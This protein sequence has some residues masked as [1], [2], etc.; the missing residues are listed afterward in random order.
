MSSR[1]GF[2]EKNNTT[3]LDV[4]LYEGSDP[5]IGVD[6]YTAMTDNGDGSY[7]CDISVSKK[8]TLVV[9]G[10]IQDEVR[11]RTLPSSDLI[12]Q[13]EFD[14]HKNADGSGGTSS[15]PTNKEHNAAAIYLADAGGR[16]S[17]TDIEA[18]LQEIAGSGRTT[19]TVKDNYDTIQNHLHAI[20]NDLITGGTTDALSAEMGKDLGDDIGD[21][22]FSTSTYLANMTNL[23]N[24]LLALDAKI[25][26]FFIRGSEPGS[27]ANLRR[28]LLFFSYDGQLI[29]TSG[30]LTMAKGI[31]CSATHGIV[32]TR[33]GSITGI[34]ASWI[35]A[36]IT[37]DRI[38][39]LKVQKNGTDLIN[40]QITDAEAANLKDSTTHAAGDY[41]FSAGD[42]IGMAYAI[43]A[44]GDYLDDVMIMVELTLATS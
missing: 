18:A 10:V 41:T 25:W 20:I 9:E 33:A 5:N 17:G 38:I 32:M 7:Y 31:A 3:G 24:A 23:T 15:P 13:I 44:S 22:D 19:Q 29:G 35:G 16:Y 39:Y 2:R 30:Y 14:A 42:K 1:I 26:E 43:D 37:S 8:Y 27:E 40:L 36:N 34:S 21:M 11:G 6:P 4:R 12:N 28:I